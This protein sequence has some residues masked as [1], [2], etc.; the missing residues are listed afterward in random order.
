MLMEIVCDFFTVLGDFECNFEA[1]LCGWLN[2]R[3][4]TMDWTRHL[5][6]TSTEY[7]GPEHDHTVGSECFIISRYKPIM[8][9]PR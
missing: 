9:L 7:S 2:L 4:D 5:G 3:D 1:S 6:A 8:S